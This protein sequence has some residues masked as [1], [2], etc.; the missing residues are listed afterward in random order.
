MGDMVLKY[1]LVS[2]LVLR[3]L[4]A[5]ETAS[6]SASPSCGAR[7]ACWGPIVIVALVEC[8]AKGIVIII[9]PPHGSTILTRSL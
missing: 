3:S 4:L 8:P 7:V 6:N 9:S 5:A 1:P 2:V